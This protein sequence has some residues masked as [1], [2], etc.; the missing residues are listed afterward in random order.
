MKNGA[1]SRSCVKIYCPRIHTYF[2]MIVIGCQQ[3]S[4][5]WQKISEATK[6][7][8]PEEV[9]HINRHCFDFRPTFGFFARLSFCVGIFPCNSSS[10]A[11][12]EGTGSPANT[13]C[14]NTVS[15]TNHIGSESFPIKDQGNAE[16][17]R[18]QQHKARHNHPEPRP[19][20]RLT[21][22]LSHRN[23]GKK[24]GGE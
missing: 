6:D 16:G 4:R 7:V 2:S 19:I 15:H 8:A 5:K 9:F 23:G 20:L 10:Y 1:R 14:S 24:L 17:Q 3:N 22:E 21:G 18:C 13:S 11:S 12:S